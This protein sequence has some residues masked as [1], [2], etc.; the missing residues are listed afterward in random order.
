MKVV[1][2]ITGLDTGGAEMMLYKLLASLQDEKIELS[3]I[4]LM[5]KGRVAKKIEALGVQVES[6]DISREVK[7]DW[8]TLKNLRKLILG[9]NIDIVQGWMYHGNIVATLV[10]F[11]SF[12]MGRRI[13]LFWNV[14][15]TL[16]DL[17]NEKIQTQWV[18]RISC[19][20]SFFSKKI[21]YNSMLSMQQHSKIGFSSRKIKMI[22]NGFD[23]QNFRPNFQ[24]YQQF[25]QELG[26][27]E[28][29]FLIGHIS[30]LHPMKDH[31]TL[32]RTIDRVMKILVGSSSKQ[33][34]IFILVGHG[35]TNKL[36]NNPAIR[37]L[38]ER[39]DI[40][41]VMS[42]M[43]LVISSSAWGEGFPNVIGEAM[44]SEVPCVVT[45]VG[46]SAYIVDKCGR[47]CSVGDDQCLANSI[48]KL[49]EDSDER[50]LLGKCARQRIERY[51]SIDKI[52]KEY[53]LE[54][55]Y[56]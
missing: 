20:L 22:S 33:K 19:W 39:S 45:N 38:G 1:H 2:V 40:P 50:K 5:K 29:T 42:A 30:R 4:S 7:I 48:V 8:K 3:V 17:N 34:V 54:W 10:A 27:S 28:G 15:Q 53:L 14:R 46:D 31:A 32:F 21:I 44:A 41:K 16:Y 23:L 43:D 13:K 49:I 6:L 47:V 11:L 55:G 24:F 25:R 12:L 18:I 56:K 35:I 36:S 37:F 51:Y 9:S 52:K 26:V